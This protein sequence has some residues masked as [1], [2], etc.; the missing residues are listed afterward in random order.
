M[1]T[2]S[3]FG[4]NHASCLL[5]PAHRRVDAPLRLCAVGVHLEIEHSAF[6]SLGFKGLGLRFYG[7]GLMF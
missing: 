4:R 7:A 3:A 1:R 6:E 5:S 2:A